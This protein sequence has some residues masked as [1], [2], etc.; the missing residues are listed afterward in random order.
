MKMKSEADE[1]LFFGI[2]TDEVSMRTNILI[3]FFTGRSSCI[4]RRRSE[5]ILN[6]QTT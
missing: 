4:E 1:C 6:K 3:L 5:D 2:L